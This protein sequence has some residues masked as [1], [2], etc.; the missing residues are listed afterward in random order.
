MWMWTLSLALADP[1]P[2][3]LV[4]CWQTAPDAAFHS[5]ET[6]LGPMKGT[7]VGALRCSPRGRPTPSVTTARGGAPSCPTRGVRAEARFWPVGA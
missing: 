1:S 2:D 5:R 3:F 7:L 6:W 4:G